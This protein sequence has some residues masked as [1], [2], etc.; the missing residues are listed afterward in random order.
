MDLGKL[1]ESVYDRSVVKVIRAD[2]TKNRRPYDGAGLRADCAVLPGRGASGGLLS[3]QALAFG[4]DIQVAS[5]AYAA[6]V[7]NMIA[8]CAN[9]AVSGMFDSY[10]DLM[11]SVPEKL[12][13]IKV[14]KT[15]E[16]VAALA[17]ETGIPLLG[18][19]VQVLPAVQE[20]VASCVV[21]AGIGN[22]AVTAKRA[23]CDE[24]IV[25]TK[26]IGLEGTAMIADG[27]FNALCERYPKDIVEEAAGFYRYL[28]VAPEAATAVKS[29]AGYLLVPR[30]GGIFGGLWRLA[31][32]NGVGLVVDLK[33]IPVR[34]E[35][36]EVC[37]FFDLD[38]YELM[39]GGCLLATTENGSALVRALEESGIPAAVI[40]RTAQGNDRIIRHAQEERFLGPARG[41]AIFRYKEKA[42]SDREHI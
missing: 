29:G 3:G 41:D 27:S 2:P 20:P 31:A 42:V 7:D 5:R 37:E 25:M 8:C 11:L 19:N 35:T 16:S 10:A 1:T 13:E 15:I 14:R 23:R 30:E 34:Q 17:K 22:I 4:T 9:C 21:S 36:I 33:S 12:R 18:C 39:A 32:E 6:A 38:P 24:D 40:G 26:W 28:S